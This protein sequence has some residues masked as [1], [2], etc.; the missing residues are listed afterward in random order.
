MKT[1]SATKLV[2]LSYRPFYYIT[3]GGLYRLVQ[4]NPTE[5]LAAEVCLEVKGSETKV[6]ST[7]SKQRRGKVC[8]PRQEAGGRIRWCC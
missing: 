1:L 2:A 3:A 7:A 5:N 8:W 4:M 6:S